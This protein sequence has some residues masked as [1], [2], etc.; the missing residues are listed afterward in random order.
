MS[1][2][3]HQPGDPRRRGLGKGLGAL[4]PGAQVVGQERPAEVA[5]THL[6][7]NPLQ[8]RHVM[9]AQELSGLVESIRRHGVL[10]P[11]VVR[12]S[13]EG[14]EVVAGERRWRAAEAAGLTS[15]PAIVRSL[16][17]QEALELALVENL[18][19]EDLNPIERA[20]AYSRLMQE[21]GLTQEQI[22]DRV[23]KSQPSVANALRL[24]HLPPQVQA[25]LEA[26]RIS[27]GHARA[28]L[29]VGT[30]VVLLRLWE[31][32]ERRGLSVRE[33]EA[34]A[35][36]SI[37]REIQTRRRVGKDPEFRSLE[38]DLSRRYGTKVVMDGTRRRGRLA[39]DYYSEDDLQRLLDLL[40]A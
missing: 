36:R 32:V 22:A 27:E 26:G 14:Y 4:I 39:F 21:F 15:V 31:R 1:D 11:I 5:L 38:Q 20:R 35:R 30:E 6:R 28:L 29:S 33:T 10:Q 3:P 40:L 18:Q 9:D 8:P 12:P 2:S 13:V 17:D 37:S 34:L 25:S 19:R 16:T 23:G 7:A 24:L